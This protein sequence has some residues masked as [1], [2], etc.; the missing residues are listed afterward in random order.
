ML[1]RC[2][3]KE[4]SKYNVEKVFQ[5]GTLTSGSHWGLSCCRKQS[6]T[7]AKRMKDT[8]E[9]L[10]VWRPPD[11][12]IR[13]KLAKENY[14]HAH[15]RARAHTHAHTH[16]RACTHT[17]THTNTPSH[18]IS[19][20]RLSCVYFCLKLLLFFCLTSLRSVLRKSVVALPFQ[21]INLFFR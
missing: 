14:K 1:W 8:H 10:L 11:Q 19:R 16:A 13:N 12:Q 2:V 5:V 6:K 20:L 3:E 4:W 18:T 9:R 17:H 7:K 15:M 21:E